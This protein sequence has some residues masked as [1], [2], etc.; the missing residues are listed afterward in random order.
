MKHADFP[1]MR[2]V[3]ANGVINM[4]YITVHTTSRSNIAK[5]QIDCANYFLA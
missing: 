5:K 3:I 2:R 4:R 1:R